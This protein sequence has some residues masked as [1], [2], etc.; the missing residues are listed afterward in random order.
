M[1]NLSYVYD[2][3]PFSSRFLSEIYI[4]RTREEADSFVCGETE[5]VCPERVENYCEKEPVLKDGLPVTT[6]KVTRFGGY[7]LKRIQSTARKY[8]G[9]VVL[10]HQQE[11][12]SWPDG[13]V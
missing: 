2:N 5:R 3:T 6:K 7:G 9:P 13:T 12:D 8:G 4:I 11:I 1:S 10:P